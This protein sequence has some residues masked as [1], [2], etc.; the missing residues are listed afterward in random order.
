MSA[1]FSLKPMQ[2]TP[3]FSVVQSMSFI[4]SGRTLGRW[5]NLFKCDYQNRH[6]ID[7]MLQTRYGANLHFKAFN[8]AT[9]ESQSSELFQ[10]YCSVQAHYPRL[11]G[12]QCHGDFTGEKFWEPI[13]WKP[14]AT[15]EPRAATP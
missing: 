6:L 2:R 3:R 5:E 12:P 7:D 9:N 4:N 14:Q 1:R 8:I 11:S 15:Q 10:W 13:F